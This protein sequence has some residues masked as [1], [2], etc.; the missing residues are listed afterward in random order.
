MEGMSCFYVPFDDLLW[1][2][3]SVRINFMIGLH[4]LYGFIF[5]L[6]EVKII[7]IRGNPKIS[8]SM[9]R[10]AIRDKEALE[11]TGQPDQKIPV[12]FLI[13]QKE[14]R[15]YPSV[16]QAVFDLRPLL[17]LQHFLHHLLIGG[18]QVQKTPAHR[19]TLPVHRIGTRFQL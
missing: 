10:T 13:L 17:I 12:G 8:P 19:N 2:Q 15:D 7:F 1:K 18:I 9:I 14:V 3:F 5:F 11:L 6:A 4:I 16:C